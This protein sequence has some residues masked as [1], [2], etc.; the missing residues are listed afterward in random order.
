MC[1]SAVF[2]NR[3]M[4]SIRRHYYGHEHDVGILGDTLSTVRF[5][6]VRSRDAMGD[7]NT[8]GT[9]IAGHEISMGDTLTAT[10]VD[11]GAYEM[12]EFSERRGF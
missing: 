6:H 1:V 9:T 5:A 10:V 4:I 2:A 7:S 3:L 8:G 12:Q 11:D